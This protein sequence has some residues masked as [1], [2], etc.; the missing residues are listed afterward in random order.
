LGRSADRRFDCGD[1]CGDLYC[2]WSRF[3][4]LARIA[5][6]GQGAYRGLISKVLSRL[7]PRGGVV[8]QRSAKPFTPVQFWS[9]PPIKSIIYV[10]ILQ[11]NISRQRFVSNPRE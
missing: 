10:K 1:F 3:V 5:E 11:S 9:W 8:T 2:F 4:R 7:G 6:N